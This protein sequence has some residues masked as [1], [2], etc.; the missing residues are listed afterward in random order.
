MKK[1]SNKKLDYIIGNT[2][3]RNIG[4]GEK[5]SSIKIYSSNGL[6]AQFESLSKEILAKEI[7]IFLEKKFN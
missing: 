2:V 4:F 6:E 1:I 7:V 5:E 3:G